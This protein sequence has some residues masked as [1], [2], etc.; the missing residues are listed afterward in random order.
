VKDWSRRLHHIWRVG[1]RF[2]CDFLCLIVLE[3]IHLKIQTLVNENGNS[4]LTFQSV[5]DF[6]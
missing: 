4:L 6:W 5:R 3:K 1:C 2:F